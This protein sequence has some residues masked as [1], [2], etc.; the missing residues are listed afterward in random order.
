MIDLTRGLFVS[1]PARV[2]SHHHGPRE[3]SLTIAEC[4]I[5]GLGPLAFKL[6]VAGDLDTET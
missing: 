6:F 4:S 2:F 1:L 3:A 5:L